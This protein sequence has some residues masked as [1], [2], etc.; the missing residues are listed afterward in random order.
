MAEMDSDAAIFRGFYLRAAGEGATWDSACDRYPSFASWV[1]NMRRTFPQKAKLTCMCRVCV[2]NCLVFLFFFPSSTWVN[3]YKKETVKKK[4]KGRRKKGSTS[5]NQ[6]SL[7]IN[8]FFLNSKTIEHNSVIC[9]NHI[10]FSLK[11]SNHMGGRFFF[12][13]F[14]N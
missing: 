12:S 2:L 14:F 7:K 1:D 11:V 10:I 13:F 3:S 9:F 6:T 4:K 8:Q 5:T